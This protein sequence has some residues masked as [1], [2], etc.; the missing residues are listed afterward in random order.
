MNLRD[1]TVLVTGGAVRLGRALCEA[2]AAR[3]CRIVIHYHRSDGAARTLA[4]RLKRRDGRAWAIA[5]DLREPDMAARI[6]A[7]AARV[8]GRL[9]V[10]INNAAVFEKRS[11]AEIAE[12]DIRRAWEVNVLAPLLLMQAF[13]RRG[14]R[15]KIINLLDC[16]IAVPDPPVTPYLLT[17]S[18]LADLTVRAA[19]EMAPRITVNA[20]APGAVLRP[21]GKVNREKAGCLPLAR[22]PMVSE[23]VQAV[24]F[25]LEC[26]AVTG[27]IIYVDSGRHL[28]GSVEC[29]M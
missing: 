18:T 6:V 7:K 4:A 8:A 25:L 22:R 15:G 28:N 11:L 17:K 3:G 23:V 2:L 10:L 26:D 24:L 21:A 12:S 9:D 1:K 5:G 27:Q 16:R 14:R 19:L 13:A 29:R 20:V